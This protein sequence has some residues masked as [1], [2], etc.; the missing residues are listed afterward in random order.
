MSNYIQPD[1][2]GLITSLFIF[3][4]KTFFMKPISQICFLVLTASILASNA[5]QKDH[6]TSPQNRSFEN[7]EGSWTPSDRDGEGV[8]VLGQAKTNPYAVENIRQAYNSLY[9][10]DISTLNPNYLYVRFLPQ[11]PNDVKILLESNLDL[12][13]FPLHYEIVSIGEYYHDPS[14][15]DST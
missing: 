12:W 9:E 1:E 7:S 4:L 10:P 5:C 8:T 14:L 15:A 6:I 11:S 3:I 2:K 13:D